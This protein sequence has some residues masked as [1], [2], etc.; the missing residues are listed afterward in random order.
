MHSTWEAVFLKL[1]AKLASEWMFIQVNFHPIQEIGPKV[2]FRGWALFHEWV[3]FPDTT[4]IIDT[5]DP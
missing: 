5:C 2:L 1:H 4:V 3:L